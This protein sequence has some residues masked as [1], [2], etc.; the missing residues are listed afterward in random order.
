VLWLRNPDDSRNI[1]SVRTFFVVKKIFSEVARNFSLAESSMTTGIEKLAIEIEE[2]A[3]GVYPSETP[4]QDLLISKARKIQQL[5]RSRKS[6][7]EKALVC[8]KCDRR[9]IFDSVTG[10]YHSYLCPGCGHRIGVL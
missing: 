2:I 1:P 3:N 7:R 8:Q 5:A 9:M 6:I 4:T 10:T